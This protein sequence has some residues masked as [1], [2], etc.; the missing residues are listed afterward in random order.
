MYLSRI[1]LDTGRRETISALSN[2]QKIHGAVES[3]FADLRPQEQLSLFVDNTGCH[4]KRR[5]WRL[6]ELGGNL[7]LLVLSEDIPDLTAA[8]KQFGYPGAVPETKDYTPLLDRI[9]TDSRW[10]FRLTANP[11]ISIK[12]SAGDNRGRVKAH[13]TVAHQEE[14]L[15]E[16]AAA[17]GFSLEPGEYRVTKSQTH[18]FKKHGNH[19]VTLISVTYDGI[20]TVTDPDKFRQTL[21][22]G[23]GRGKAYGNGLLTIVRLHVNG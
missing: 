2:P 4:G 1:K 17:N 7:Y 23:I 10:Q 11:T 12:T 6:D 9:T 19:P 16:R 15:A 8:T 18:S 5:L 22:H 13:V 21:T 14:W 20:L 3:A